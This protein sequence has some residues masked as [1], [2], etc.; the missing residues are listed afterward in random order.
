MPAPQGL[1][2]PR[3]V[4]VLPLPRLPKADRSQ[5]REKPANPAARIHARGISS[6]QRGASGSEKVKS[7]S[8]DCVFKVK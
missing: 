3:E 8:G 7:I 2:D 6:E 5:G 4:S 1:P